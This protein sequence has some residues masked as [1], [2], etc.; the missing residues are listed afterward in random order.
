MYPK[1]AA[2]RED[3]AAKVAEARAL[4]DAAEGENRDLNE[5]E[6]V[7]LK[8][9]K[10]E[11]ASFDKRIERQE[12]LDEAEA[13][14]AGDSRPLIQ[15]HDMIEDDDQRG[16]AN[17]GD[18]FKAVV[19]AGLNDPVVDDRLRI[20]AAPTSYNSGNSGADGGFAVPPAFSREIYQHSL[21][22]ASIVP[23]TDNDDVEGNSMTIPT[24]ETTPW[25]SSGVQAYWAR[26]GAQGTQ[27]KGE[28]DQQSLKLEKLFALVPVTDEIIADA[29][30]MSSY[31]PRKS[32]EAILYKTNDALVNGDGVGKPGGILNA[33]A[34]VTQAKKTSQTADTIV[35]ENILKMF[36]RCTNPSRGVW[37][38]N[39][40]AWNQLPLLTIGDQ[41]MFV[42]PG[43]GLQG[44]P[45]GTLLGRPVM[46]MEQCQ[47]LGDKGD[48]YFVDWQGYKTITKAGGVETATSM[49]LWFDYDMMAFRTT[50]RIAGRPWLESAITP[51]NSAITRSPFVTLAARA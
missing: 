28:L 15:T 34:L 14:T 41:P 51:P 7:Q 49:H 50:Y 47:T 18:Y 16:F 27:S 17:A 35:A 37:M 39:P 24:D 44:A 2:L 6:S 48:I 8:G 30:F 5:D 20:G 32:G 33:G 25:G 31:I 22:E 11:I 46:L 21:G 40:D 4:I 29:T 23:L 13:V 3:R 38:V 12:E 10:T 43:A 1:I 36:A 45:G 9:I 26:E 42:A 19:A